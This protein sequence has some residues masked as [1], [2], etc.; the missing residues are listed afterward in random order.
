M[1]TALGTDLRSK[2][3]IASRGLAG[4]L[5]APRWRGASLLH[6]AATPVL[7]IVVLAL[8][9]AYIQ[10][11]MPLDNVESRD[12]NRGSI[13]EQFRQHLW[14]VTVSSALVLVLAIPFGVALTRPRLRWISPAVLAAANLGQGVPVIGLLVLLAVWGHTGF[15]PAVLALMLVSFLSVLRN[16]MVGL[17][18]VDR[19]VIEAARGMGLSR[20]T[21][22]RSVELPMA[23]PVMMAGVRVALILNVG[24]AALAAY[25]DAGGFGKMIYDG[26]T[27]YRTPVLLTGSVLTGVLALT[28]DW[29]AGIAERALSPVGLH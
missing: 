1:T 27:L 15:W 20:W 4:V 6:L 7:M 23:V 3:E 9:Y 24:S 28:I 12:L 16:T 17:D 25:T 18:A 22:L 8:L 10:S 13:L 21:V 14:L 5:L 29:L 26:I 2:D 19:S 11:Q